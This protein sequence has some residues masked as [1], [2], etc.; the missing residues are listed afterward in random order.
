[1]WNH[2]AGLVEAATVMAGDLQDE[3][4]SHLRWLWSNG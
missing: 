1:M 4:K 2:N 3:V